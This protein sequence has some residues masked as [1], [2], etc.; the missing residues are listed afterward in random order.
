MKL[1]PFLYDIY[2]F[3]TVTFFFTEGL[4]AREG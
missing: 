4:F 2:Q 1:K 3:K